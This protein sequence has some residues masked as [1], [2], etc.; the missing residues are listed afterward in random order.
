MDQ[1]GFQ[2]SHP[3]VRICVAVCGF[4]F[5]VPLL[6][7]SAKPIF[8][9]T[10]LR[11]DTFVTRS[12]AEAHASVD[13]AS[14]PSKVALYNQAV[15]LFN[16]QKYEDAAS[17][18]L[19]ACNFVAQAC[20]NLGFM[21]RNGL[22]MEKS[23]QLAAS[24]YERGCDDGDAVG[25]ANLGIMY[26]KHELPGD[27]SRAAELFD[28][29]CKGGDSAGCRG[30]GYLY[31]HGFGVAIDQS[32]ADELYHLAD[33]LSHVHQI[34]FRVQDG[35]VLISPVLNGKTVLMVVDTGSTRTAFDR[36]VLPTSLSLQRS[37]HLSTVTGTTK[38][39]VLNLSWN[40]DG[41]LISFPALVGDFHLPHGAV[42]LL[43][44][45]LLSTFRSV[46][47]DYITMVL[48]LEERSAAGTQ[49]SR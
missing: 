38:A 34:P 3:L 10:E 15:G 28:R 18:Y 32:H 16:E 36:R 1:R 42:G 39:D 45:D 27:S 40:L 26:W 35:M 11:T 44:S 49:Q 2:S 41:R 19:K 14:E 46:R 37:T 13:S 24:W 30:L 12:N 9:T 48:T 25:C 23:Y 20:T 7:Q 33:R 5:G 43:G 8:P 31:E 22:G 17:T 29:A 4:L 47:F 21:F 6:S